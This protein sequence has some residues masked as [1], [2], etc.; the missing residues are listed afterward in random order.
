MKSETFSDWLYNY[1]LPQYT[2]YPGLCSVFI[3][4]NYNIYQNKV[5]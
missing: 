3:M 2:P 1:I 4:D 5:F